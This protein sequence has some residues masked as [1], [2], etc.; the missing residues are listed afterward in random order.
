MINFFQVL[1]S[2]CIRYT[3]HSSASAVS[4]NSESD[5]S[6]SSST[7]NLKQE[8]KKLKL[9][10]KEEQQKSQ[11]LIDNLDTNIICVVCF[12]NIKN[13]LAIP[14]NHI[15]L[16]NTCRLQIDTCPLCR[17]KIEKYCMVYL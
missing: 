13:I 12:D 10:I 15:C 6:F 16:C 8:N 14:C 9:Q 11:D 2:N 4:A 5:Y 1:I 7:K 17:V 3:P